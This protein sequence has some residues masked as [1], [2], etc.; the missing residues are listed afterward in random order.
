[1]RRSLSVAWLL[2]APAAFA[3]PLLSSGPMLGYAEMT[4]VAIW[5]QTTEDARVQLSYWPKPNPLAAR[6]TQVIV[7]KGATDHIARFVVSDLDFGTRYVY[8]LS[9]NGIDVT[10]PYP[11]EFQTQPHWRFRGEPPSFKIAFGSCAYMNEPKFDRPGTPYGGDPEIMTS[12]AAKRP[13]LMLWLGDNIYY[14]EPDWLT[15]AAMRYRWRTDRRLPE[16]QPLLATA[17]HYAIWDDHDFG[18]NDSDRSFRLRGAALKVF[19]D[20]WPS[21]VRGT[22]ETAGCFFRFEWGD[23]EFFM[24]DDRYWRTPNRYPDGP[25]KVMFGK[26]QLQ[27][28]KD[29]LVDSDATFKIVCNGNQMTNPMM[30]FEAFGR[31]PGE[32]KELFDFIAQAGISGVLFLTGDR[33][34]TELLKVQW[35]GVKYPWY[36]YTSSP[37][38]SGGGRNDREENNPARVPGTWVTRLRNFGTVDVSGPRGDRKLVLQAFDK[39]GKRLWI[40]AI[41]Q[42]EIVPAR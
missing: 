9:I 42:S 19:E 41:R 36:E 2:L 17:N 37:L 31:F 3:H 22:P 7:T 26:A 28:L 23:V 1:M 27:W 38:M 32:Q 13:D 33:H 11:L 29:S 10:R 25:D 34:A 21:V 24:L 20:Y 30:F 4:E 15:E 5:V 39:D 40:H 18:P 8:R 16:L 6:K 12:I 35:P 14:R